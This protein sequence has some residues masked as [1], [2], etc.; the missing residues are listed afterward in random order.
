L[1]RDHFLTSDPAGGW[2]DRLDRGGACLSKFM[3][4]STLY[5]VVCAIDEL[6][7]FATGSPDPSA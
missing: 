3:P 1:L 2:R 6:N 7:R 4:A 5:H